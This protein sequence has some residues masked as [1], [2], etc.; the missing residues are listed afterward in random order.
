MAGELRI[1]DTVVSFNLEVGRGSEEAIE[2][3]RRLLDDQPSTD[4]LCL[5]EA[6]NYAA[7]LRKAF[8]GGW[9]FYAKEGWVESQ[10]CPVMV[11]KQSGFPPRTFG[12][13]WGVVRNYTNWTGPLY[14]KEHP[15]RTWTWVKAGQV[16]VMSLHRCTEGKDKNQRAYKEEATKLSLFMTMRTGKPLIIIG[17]TNTAPRAAHSG[18]MREI[19]SQVG[20]RLVWDDREMS[21]DYALVSREVHGDVRRTESY[22]SDHKAAVMKKIWIKSE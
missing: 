21:V 3:I 14:G 8:E 18:S 22:G 16:Y 5:Q 15:G 6:E 20:G 17:D 10:N 19:A 2:S 12:R 9:N 4:V 11:R 1:P 7:D 13:G